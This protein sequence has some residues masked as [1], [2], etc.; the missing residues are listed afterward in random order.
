[1]AV[2]V[3][4]LMNPKLQTIGLVAALMFSGH[5]QD[6]QAG[7]IN[8]FAFDDNAFAFTSGW[9]WIFEDDTWATAPVT[10]V[11]PNGHWEVTLQG[12]ADRSLR[13]TSRH[14]TAPDGLPEIAPNALSFFDYA[15]A[16]GGNGIGPVVTV[17]DHPAIPDHFDQYEMTT[18]R[19]LGPVFVVDFS[20]RHMGPPPPFPDLELRTIPEPSTVILLGAGLAGLLGY[21]RPRRKQSL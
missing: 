18:T 6:L 21:A 4:I 13:D 15:L 5:V 16:A 9:S 3:G 1:M 7:S 11:G 14:L 19:P 2:K 12:F 10:V 17:F 20:G 8:N